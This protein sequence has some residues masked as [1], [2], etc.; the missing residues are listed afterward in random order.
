VLT[1]CAS[2]PPIFNDSVI[3]WMG[4]TTKLVDIYFSSEM[5]V[6]GF[7]LSRKQWLVLMILNTHGPQMQ[8]DLSIVTE[9]NKSSL[10]RLLDVI[11]KRE[12]VKRVSSKE[13]KRINYIHLTEAGEKVLEKTVP[14]VQGLID[15]LQE[16]ISQEEKKITIEV[17][18]KIQANICK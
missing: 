9:R 12:L 4:K 8:N 18:K 14:F 17:F 1:K 11:E 3:P 15:K 5:K 13:D 7:N 2:A 6:F 10:K 16:G